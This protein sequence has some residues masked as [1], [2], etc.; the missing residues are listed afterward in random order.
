MINKNGLVFTEETLDGYFE[1]KW[2]LIRLLKYAIKIS[3]KRF[4]PM[5][6]YFSLMP[7]FWTWA[8]GLIKPDMDLK[9]KKLINPK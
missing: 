1:P 4:L 3:W 6:G 8:I 5:L 2:H 9:K 7:F